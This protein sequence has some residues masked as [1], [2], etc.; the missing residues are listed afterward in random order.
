MEATREDGLPIGSL[1][2]PREL[3]MVKKRL[4]P[5]Q[6]ENHGSDPGRRTSH[7]FPAT[8]AGTG[9]GQKEA[10]TLSRGER[11]D[12]ELEL[13]GADRRRKTKDHG[14]R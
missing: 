7:W 8:A 4:P 12:S 10:S 11:R 1:P 9:D 5:F 6:E 13:E 3:E 14:G 2:P